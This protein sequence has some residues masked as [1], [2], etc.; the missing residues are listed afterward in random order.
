MAAAGKGPIRLGIAPIGWTNNDLPELGGDIPLEQCLSEARRAGFSGVENGAKFPL[1]PKE[2]RPILAAH[3]LAL[4]TGWFSGELRHRTLDDEQRRL[5][6]TL[7]LYQELAA[8]VLLYAETTG[9]VQ[10]RMDV[11]VSDRPIMSEEAFKPYGEKL[12]ALAD[13]LASEGVPMTYHHH[14]GTVV[15]TEREIDL[16][17]VN[18]DISVGLLLDTGHL[19]FAGGDVLA[20]TRRHG[21][22]INHVHCKDLRT[23]VL[24]RLEA[25][26]WSFL[27][28]VIEGVFTVPGDGSIDFS[29][30]AKV[31]AE[32]GYAGWVVVEAE[33]DPKKANPLEMAQIGHQT[34]TDAF[35]AAGFQISD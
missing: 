32:I 13:W 16:L 10:S 2:L 35:T 30:F 11:P 7:R 15:E 29:P 26:R 12:T 17:M 22:R 34:L 24:A 14:M 8:P 6:Q 21:A 19:T 4:I 1:D 23:G 25:E 3:G 28:G 31:L 5:R 9:T 27:K 20:T 33:Q 18:T